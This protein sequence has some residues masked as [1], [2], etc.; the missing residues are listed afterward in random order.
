MLTLLILH[1][2]IVVINIK[3]SLDNYYIVEFSQFNK[4]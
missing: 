2:K 1:Y 3:Y 4:T